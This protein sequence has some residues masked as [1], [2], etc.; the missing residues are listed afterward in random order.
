MR[1]ASAGAVN[2]PM[3]QPDFIERV[4][5]LDPKATY[6]VYCRSGNRSKSAV[7]QMQ[8]AGITHIY[9]LAEGTNGWTAAGQELVQKQ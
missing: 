9:E 8:G 2:I 4:A 5:Q 1:S 7:A 6:A 3:Q